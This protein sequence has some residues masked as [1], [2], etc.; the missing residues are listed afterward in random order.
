MEDLNS[1]AVSLQ[2]SFKPMSNH[3]VAIAGRKLTSLLGSMGVWALTPV[4][5]S[6]T[7]LPAASLVVGGGRGRAGKVSQPAQ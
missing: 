3:F 7:D 4:A 5:S 2:P 6:P 1:I